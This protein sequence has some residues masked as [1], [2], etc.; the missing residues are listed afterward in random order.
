VVRLSSVRLS[1][2]QALPIAS[3]ERTS[4]SSFRDILAVITVGSP[5]PPSTISSRFCVLSQLCFTP[6]PSVSDATE[7]SRAAMY[8]S[9]DGADISQRDSRP[10]YAHSELRNDEPR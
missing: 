10:G 3:H 4:K 6:E 7:P 2:K 5:L 9:E 1:G 8:E